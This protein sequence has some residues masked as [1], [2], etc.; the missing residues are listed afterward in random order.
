M[1]GDIAAIDRAAAESLIDWWQEAGVDMAVGDAPRDWLR[2]NT[3][4][5]AP[6]APS[7]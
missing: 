3:P 7:T 5:A 6:A 1:G 2:L 4:S